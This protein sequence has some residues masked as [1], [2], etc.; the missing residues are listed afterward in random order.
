MHTSYQF[1]SNFPPPAINS[2]I[3]T[4]FFKLEYN[5][6]TMLCQF[7]LY[8]KTNQLYAQIYPF[9]LN[10]CPTHSTSYP[11]GL[12][13]STQMSSLCYKSR[14]PVLN[15]YTHDSVYMSIL[16]SHFIPIPLPHNYAHMS[17]LYVCVSI[18]ALK[19]GSSVPFFRFL[20]YVLIYD[21]CFSVSY[22]LQSVPEKE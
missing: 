9:L 5:G 6:F 20:I 15:Y 4:S 22:L 7:M 17:V 18:P 11:S 12:S 1:F 13:W 19:I 8:N 10:L 14:F 3:T 21:L 2:I 16:I